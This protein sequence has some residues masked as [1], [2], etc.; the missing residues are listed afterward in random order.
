MTALFFEREKM[1]KQNYNFATAISMVIGC[2]IG[3]GIFF[4]ADDIL[5]AV[6]GNVA[7]GL[8]GFFI[9]GI[10]VLFGALTVSYYAELDKDN[11]GLIGYA[12]MAVGRKFSYVVGWLMISCYFPTLMVILALITADYIGML[13]GIDSQLFITV[14]T[15]ILLVTN[16]YINL[17]FPK[18]AGQIQVYSTVAKL[19]PLVLIG[20]IGALFFSSPVETEVASQTLSGGSPMSALI[21][22]AFAF[23]GWIVAT[24]IAN[25]LEDSKRNL[26]RALAWGSVAIMVI[27]SVYFFGLTRILSP[28]DIVSLGDDHIMVA[29]QALVGPIGAKLILVF[30][31]ISVYGGFNGMTLAFVRLPEELIEIGLMKLPTKYKDNS[32]K[33][34]VMLASVITIFWF[35]IEQLIDYGL[36]FTNL[37]ES[38]DIS[39]MPIVIIYIVYIVLFLAVNKFVTKLG[40][41]KRIY[42]LIISLIATITSLMIIG[43]SLEVN[44]LLYIV[45]SIII[46]I[47]GIPMYIKE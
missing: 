42:F 38:F 44:G 19:I 13:L 27:Y 20:I 31:I 12:R 2:V 6:N 9:V 26:P 23:D 37:E 14:A 45:I 32:F 22:I 11:E 4:K 21:A 39:S 10:G 17:K 1:E 43:G 30:I 35:I 34:S 3:S 46:I 24:N 33:Y 40:I 25:D 5:V 28:A 18:G 16:M 36:I 8:L 7:V 15:F 29:S 47:I 41:G